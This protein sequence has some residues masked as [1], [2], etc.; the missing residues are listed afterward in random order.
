[1]TPPPRLGSL[2]DEVERDAAGGDE[3]EQLATASATATQLGELGDA[4][5]HH[6]V[7]RCRRNGH[8]WAEVS[9]V[10]GVS[11]QAA[12]KR[13]SGATL[14]QVGG[15]MTPRAQAVLTAAADHARA[16]RQASVGPEHLL[17]G[18]YS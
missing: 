2:I 13:F 9:A 1:M 14:P 10:L 18:L 16:M 7:R 5:L 8:S 11:R 3:L 4:L 17:L 6:L 12:H 15:R